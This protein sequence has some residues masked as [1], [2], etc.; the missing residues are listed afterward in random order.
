MSSSLP[1]W[2]LLPA[3]TAPV[4]LIG[5]W[6]L[7]AAL[8]PDD[9]SSVSG[10]I[11]AL[12]AEGAPHREVMTAGL[13]LL[14]LAHVGTAVALR[15]AATPGRVVLAVGGVASALVAVYPLPAGSGG[16]G[17]HAVAAGTGFAA[18]SVW[19]ALAAR[20]TRSSGGPGIAWGLRRGPAFTASLVL[21]G[22]VGWFVAELAADSG[23]VGLSARAAA[24][25]QSLWP[26]M[27]VLSA[28]RRR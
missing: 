25:A 8:R 24:G 26:L 23:R 3:L 28:R 13:A 11:S 18:L 7:A 6:T 15:Q 14:G 27:V 4:A 20:R 9:F 19:G 17:A 16:S 5:G 2:A 1:R 21:L 12:A 22:L 10:T